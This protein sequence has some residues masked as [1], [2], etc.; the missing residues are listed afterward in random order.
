[1]RLR[2][3]IFSTDRNDRVRVKHIA[4]PLWRTGW[5]LLGLWM[6]L[7]TGAIH[8]QTAPAELGTDLKGRPVEGVRVVGNAQV[9][10][11]IIMNVVR[12]R[13]GAA[14]DPATVEEDYK[15]IYGLRRFSNVE[16]KVEPTETGVV[17]VFVVQEQKQISTIAYRGN[18]AIDTLK[19]QE[20]VD[21][22]EGEAI[23]RFRISLA[24]R[25]I[26]TLY[27]EK[28]FP[29]AHVE[30]PPEPLSSRGELIFNIIEG[31]NVRVRKTDFVGNNSYS[32]DTLKGQIRTRY[33]IWIFRPG[34]YEPDTVEDDVAAVRRFYEQKGFFDVRVGRKLI[35]SP[36]LKE[37]EINFVIE[38]GKRYQIDRVTFKGLSIVGEAD[39][40]ARMKLLEGQFYDNEIIQR[41]IREM[42]RAYSPFGMIYQPQS[43]DPGY[44]QIDTTPVFRGQ[45]GKVE[46]IYDVREGKAYRLGRV[47]VKGNYKSQ[48]KLVLRE[49]R[50]QP[51]QLYD[52]G[53]VQDAN[54]RLRGTPYFGNVVMT[55][56]GDEPDTRDLLVE[57]EEARTAS[58]S[59]G[60]GVNSNG[61]V[62]GNI[63]YEQRNFDLLNWPDSWG[64]IFTDKA[65]TGAGQN[66]RASFEPGTQATNASLR[67]T[68]PYIFDQPYS[69]TG[70]IYLRDREREHYDD[71]RIGTRL[72]F[73][74]RF[75]YV[76]SGLIT[77]RLEQVG[78]S[79]IEDRDVR[80]QEILDAD[81]D[82]F[83]SSL[84][85][86]L[87]RDTTTRG[88]LPAKGTTTTISYE[89][90]GALGGD[91]DFH[92]YTLTWDGF[93]KLSEDLL[94]R[95]TILEL[96]TD[97]GYIAG[98]GPFF[99]R[100][101]GG[102]LGSIRGFEFRGVSP[103]SGAD[104]D[105]VGG[106]F[107]LTY[108][109]Q[110]SFPVAGENLRGVVFH[111]GGTIEE[112]FKLD[113]FRSSIGAGV[114]LTLPFFGQAP[115]ALDFAYPL[116]KN[117]EDDTQFISFSFGFVQ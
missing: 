32:T 21:S 87:R 27:R 70:E 76:Y 35:W 51:G 64:E 22:R 65:F 103:R 28:N 59:V 12:T 73:G 105:P 9:S 29:F 20:V 3:Y 13:E 104:D 57:I 8:A 107:A 96:H 41:D 33:W 48:D 75:N 18:L 5:I 86:Q 2:I 50:M 46:L 101:Y 81:G 37:L 97:M 91:Y 38:E 102:G 45:E 108:S 26:E 66:F 67:F 36:N 72:S 117:S 94:D 47:Y 52:S 17:V 113:D 100:F 15:R 40:R 95:K 44:L 34:T 24:R 43:T 7:F 31:P 19:I 115:L 42:V 112:S 74:K 25:A 1:M 53:A 83:L 58:F 56:V 6:G 71:Q 62:G 49:M 99:E 84:G 109:V 82:S 78:I 63:T 114:R 98:N 68:E 88:L 89:K 30:V 110:V 69:F 93:F 61:G 116:A 23:D 85:V 10:T 16:A 60:A 4:S 39:L 80:A 79:N 77:A 90:Y 11:A 14:Y 55:P 111:D 92:K 106:D 54:E